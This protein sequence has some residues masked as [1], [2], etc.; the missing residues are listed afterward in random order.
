MYFNQRKNLQ[1]QLQ[2]QLQLVNEIPL[3]FKLSIYYRLLFKKN[4]Y[5]KKEKNQYGFSPFEFKKLS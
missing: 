5:E 1:L 4:K 3:K 2:L